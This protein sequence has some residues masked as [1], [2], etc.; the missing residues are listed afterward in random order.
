MGGFIDDGEQ[1]L[2]ESWDNW[3]CQ[4]KW[5]ASGHVEGRFYCKEI[6]SSQLC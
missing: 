5:L 3:Q 6:K 1:T 2:P 4:F